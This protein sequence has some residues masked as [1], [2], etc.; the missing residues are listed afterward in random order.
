MPAERFLVTGALGCLG[1]WILRDLREDNVE[2]IAL[3]RTLKLDR[4]RLVMEREDLSDITFAQCDITDRDALEAA[5]DVHQP[6]HVIHLAAL[7]IPFCRADPSLGARVNVEGTTNVFEAVRSR[8]DRIR[9]IV[10]SGSVA[11]Y[12][13]ADADDVRRD[14]HAYPHPETHY[15]VY[16]AANEGAGRVYWREHGMTT[17]GL[18]PMV[19]FGAG[20]DQGMTSASTLAI[21]AAV[22]GDPFEIPH[23]GA[24]FFNYAPDVAR[25]FVLAARAEVEGALTY[26]VPGTV[27]STDDVATAIRDNVASAKVGVTGDLLPFPSDVRARNIGTIADVTVTPFPQAIQETV[28]HFRREAARATELGTVT[29]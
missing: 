11:M 27:V 19:V 18:R 8:R 24:A 25:A 1:A 9:S 12:S 15:G 29:S 3:N 21:R 4:L 20:R 6:T 13:P 23:S 26:N 14:E 16:K 5:F 17:I 10:Y 28:E 2:V 7:Q 22:A